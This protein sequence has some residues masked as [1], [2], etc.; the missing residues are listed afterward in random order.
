MKE[1]IV[2]AVPPLLPPINSFNSVS[3]N[4][5]NTGNIGSIS[6]PNANT[7]VVNKEYVDNSVAS[8]QNGSIQFS[9]NEVLS[10]ND[11]LIWN[12]GLSVNGTVNSNNGKAVL[13]SNITQTIPSGIGTPIYFVNEVINTFGTNL[14][15]TDNN[16]FTNTSGSIMYV[17]VSYSLRGE[18]IV[19]AENAVIEGYTQINGTG[20]KYGQTTNEIFASMD[21][22]VNGFAILPLNNNDFFQIYCY[23]TTGQTI[24]LSNPPLFTTSSVTI[25]QLV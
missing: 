10:G 16:T 22:G 3:A 11:N 18:S 5:I 17:F 20:M 25:W 19:Y 21:S 2:L 4:L 14:T 7:S 12:G 8:G 1:F 6:N 23:Q 15:I 13:M 24:N 9:D